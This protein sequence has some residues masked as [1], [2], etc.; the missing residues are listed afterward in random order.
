MKGSN[1]SIVIL[2]TSLLPQVVHC[3][4]SHFH[5]LL[6]KGV[7]IITYERF[8]SDATI[9]SKLASLQ[10]LCCSWP[11]SSPPTETG[12]LA[13]SKTLRVGLESFL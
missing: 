2:F 9:S 8:R 12:S 7:I 11:I 6:I 10:Y 3:G 4:R 13:R 5:I 1:N